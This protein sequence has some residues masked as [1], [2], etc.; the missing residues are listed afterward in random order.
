M[1]TKAVPKKRLGNKNWFSYIYLC[2][3]NALTQTRRI[4]FHQFVNISQTC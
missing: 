4:I 3:C 2:D 1:Q